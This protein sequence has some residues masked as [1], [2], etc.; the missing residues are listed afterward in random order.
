MKMPDDRIVVIHQ[1]DFMPY[2]GFFDRLLK[3]DVYVVL[4]NVQ[5]VHSNRGWT[6]RDKIRTASG[7]KWITVSTRKAPRDTMISEVLLS[8][9]TSWRKDNLN[10]I[11]ENYRHSPY[12]DKIMPYVDDLY[13]FSGTK[14]M[15]FNLASIRMMM[16]LF[17]ISIPIIFA[18]KLNPIGKKNELIIDIVKKLGCHRYL[19]GVGAKDYCIPEMY[20]QAGIELIWQEFRHPIYPQQYDGFIPYLSSI[21]MLFNCGIENSRKIIRGQGVSLYDMGQ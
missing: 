15:D 7:A 8:D 10:L 4:D 20:H 21:D 19:S 11:R 1:P 6:N 9:D 18:G 13:Q 17:E 3:A 14:L 16:N 12:F 2:L 5:F